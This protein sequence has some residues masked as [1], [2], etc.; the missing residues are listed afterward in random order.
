MTRRL[1]NFLAT[2]RRPYSLAQA[3]D[4]TNIPLAELE[5]IHAQAVACGDT[6]EVEPGIF[7]STQAHRGHVTVSPTPGKP[8]TWR[9]DV[10]TAQIILDDLEAAPCRSSRKLGQRLGFSHTYICTYLTALM[11]IHAIG[12]T[13]LGYS[14]L[15]RDLTR[16]GL[17]LQRGIVSQARK[18]AK[19]GAKN[20][21]WKHV[22]DHE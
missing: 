15:S 11:S 5:P 3:A 19:L 21:N 13:P 18:A 14:V 10:H 8:H 6:R 4:F 7:I 1:E 17:D 20:A 16:L 9:F 12:V 22:P 2:H